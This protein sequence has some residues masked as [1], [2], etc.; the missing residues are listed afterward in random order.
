M[1]KWCIVFDPYSTTELSYNETLNELMR[2][3]SDEPCFYGHTYLDTPYMDLMNLAWDSLT[4]NSK[5]LIQTNPNKYKDCEYLNIRHNQ[6]CLSGKFLL[7]AHNLYKL[8]SAGAL[9]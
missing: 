3:I 9:T 7:K 2:V 4:E 8:W 6:N 1:K 5:L